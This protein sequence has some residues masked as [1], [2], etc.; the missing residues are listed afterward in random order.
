MIDVALYT[1]YNLETYTNY[2]N[3]LKKLLLLKKYTKKLSRECKKI[4]HFSINF[5][6]YLFSYK[7][8]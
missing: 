5:N 6:L 8:A 3:S 1:N 4:I 7:F 2:N